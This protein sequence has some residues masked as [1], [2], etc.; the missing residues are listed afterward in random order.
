MQRSQILAET[1]R[2]QC[3]GVSSGG[4]AG[5]TSAGLL[6][7]PAQPREPHR[8]VLPR[9]HGLLQDGA[10]GLRVLHAGP[11]A[12]RRAG[13]RPLPGAL[14]PLHGRHPHAGLHQPGPPRPR[15]RLHPHHPRHGEVRAVP[16]DAGGDVQRRGDAAQ[17]PLLQADLHSERR[18]HGLR[19]PRPA[20]VG[21]RRHQL[22]P[23]ARDGAQGGAKNRSGD[24][25][26]DRQG[27][28]GARHHLSHLLPHWLL[29]GGRADAAA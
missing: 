6:A 29:A 4:G 21:R 7:Q 17:R 28:R 15:L 12:R 19:R 9:L 14:L 1:R 23:H 26:A 24:D 18:H 13:A 20:Y 11:R 8:G 22:L 2:A 27:R 5:V 16:T 10:G 3:C 25:R